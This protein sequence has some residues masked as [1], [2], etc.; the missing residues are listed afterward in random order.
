MPSLREPSHRHGICGP[1]ALVAALLLTAGVAAAEPVRLHR[2][3]VSID[4]GLTQIAVR[5]CFEGKPPETLVAGSL[6]APFALV[7]AH[8]EGS[9]KPIEPSGSL[10]MRNVP[11]DGCVAYSADVSRPIR[12]HDRGDD[13][14]HHVGR[15]LIVSVGLW[16][17]RPEKLGADEDA[18]I[19]FALPEGV[20]VST[21]WQPVFPAAR[22]T[23]RIGGTPYDWPATVAF[24]RFRERELPV[25]GA[26]LRLAVLDGAPQVDVDRIQAWL[27]EAAQMVA[28]LYGSFP[29]RQA[30]LLVVPNAR[31]NEPTPWAYVVRG[32]GPAAHFFIN[33]RR[34][35]EEFF[36]DWTAVHELSHLLLPFVD[37]EDAWLS[38]GVATYYQN[39]LRARAGRLTARDAWTK[40][41]AGF[42]RG[43]ENAA[44]M[45]LGQATES[46][47]RGGSFMRVYWEGAAIV[48]LADVRLRQ[49]TAGKQSMDTA[50]ATLHE[51]CLG[52]DRA[53]TAA[54]LF[55]KLDEITG[56]HV[57]RD[58]YETHV[59]SK[60]FPDLNGVYRV[61]G[62]QPVSGGLELLPDAPRKDVRDAIMNETAMFVSGFE[63]R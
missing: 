28:G 13:K 11:D 36:Q 35:I 60:S 57:F 43:R 5:V 12:R 48:L 39:V 41:H 58:L 59:R 32:G 46:M 24:G 38:E 47:A 30:Q 34:P 27:T 55:D 8:V 54:Q 29:V 3:T 49:L 56:T 53:W 23:F 25:G 42:E 10:S 9:R 14:V 16:F 26:K 20:A 40:M 15:D 7:E 51:C 63:G 1:R 21:P 52:E 4:P 50:L 22:P 33:Q 61:L 37:D 31:G 19:E 44:G 17:W 45:T 18:I 62:L 6:D 2:F